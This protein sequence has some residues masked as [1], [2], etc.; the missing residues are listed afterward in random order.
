MKSFT[1]IRLSL[2]K[3]V[4]GYDDSIPKINGEGFQPRIIGGHDVMEGK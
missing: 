2:L 4:L 1:L 3:I